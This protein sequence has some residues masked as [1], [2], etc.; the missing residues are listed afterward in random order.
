MSDDFRILGPILMHREQ[1]KYCGKIGRSPDPEA[2]T[3][4]EDHHREQCAAVMR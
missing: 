4:W 3:A 1:C 2:F